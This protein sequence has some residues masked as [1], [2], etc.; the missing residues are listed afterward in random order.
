MKKSD[1]TKGK[2]ILATL[3]IIGAEGF[4]NVTVRKI[5]AKAAVNIGAVN[6][7]FGSKE[8]VIAEALEHVIM[9]MKESFTA[10]DN[11]AATPHERLRNFLRGYIQTLF[12]YP[13]PIK[14]IIYQ[15][16]HGNHEEHCYQAYM[17]HEGVYKIKGLLHAI[18]PNAPEEEL[19]LHTVRLLSSIVFPLL[20]AKNI[21]YVV[22]LDMSLVENQV[23]YADF[24]AAQYW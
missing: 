9:R 7:H 20:M 24:L 16:I 8:K 11:P 12:R 2:I 21:N 3:D 6:Y 15:A 19:N 10:L 5:A 17:K 4:H 23:R 1:I 22:K 13:D 14:S 18:Y